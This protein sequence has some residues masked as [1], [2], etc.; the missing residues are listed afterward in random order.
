MSRARKLLLTALVV[1]AVPAGLL[2]LDH[3]TQ[4]ALTPSALQARLAG[5]DPPLVI[6]VRTP[7]EYAA[8]HI[9]G[10][11]S[12]PFQAMG[13]HAEALRATGG[14]LVLTCAH[15][16]RATLARLALGDADGLEVFYLEGHM[17]GWQDAGLPLESAP[18]AP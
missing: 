15:G 1:V 9:P 5:A 8:G 12:V 6:D 17:A 2:A 16:P 14:T 10:A 3:A 13:E 7:D 11:R 18:P 4:P